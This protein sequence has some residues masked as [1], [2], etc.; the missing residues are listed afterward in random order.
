M[1]KKSIGKLN[2]SNN[3]IEIIDEKGTIIQK[4]GYN[5]GSTHYLSCPESFFLHNHDLL[6]I[7]HENFRIHS[8]TSCGIFPLFNCYLFFENGI[9]CSYENV[10]KKITISYDK[11]RVSKSKSLADC[12]IKSPDEFFFQTVDGINSE[13]VFIS[14]NAPQTQF[15]FYLSRIDQAEIFP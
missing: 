2:I 3:L 12:L 15:F 1:S 4:L 10:S 11:S 14:V 7:D 6:F 9:I 8:I 13:N 5:N